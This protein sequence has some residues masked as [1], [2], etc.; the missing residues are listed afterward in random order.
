M[1][2]RFINS[3]FF[4]LIYYFYRLV[5]GKGPQTTSRVLQIKRVLEPLVCLTTLS[6]AQIISRRLIAATVSE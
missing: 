5:R 2:L 1:S 6:L 3:Y 4:K